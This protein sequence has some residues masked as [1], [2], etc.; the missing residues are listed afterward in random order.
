MYSA[1]ENAM[2]TK[3]GKQFNVWD[4]EAYLNYCKKIQ[5]SIPERVWIEDYYRKYFRP[6][7]VYNDNMY[8]SMLEGGQKKY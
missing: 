6:N 7:E 2:V 1:L 4:P 3:D 8:N 5:S